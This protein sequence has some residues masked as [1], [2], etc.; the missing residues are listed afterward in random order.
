[1]VIHTD[2][3]VGDLDF[4]YALLSKCEAL[5]KLPEQ[6]HGIKVGVLTSAP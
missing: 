3:E 4:N 5:D 1:M 6:V 2:V